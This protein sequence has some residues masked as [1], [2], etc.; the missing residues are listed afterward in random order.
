MTT[1]PRV[2][3]PV[4]AEAIADRVIRALGSLGVRPATLHLEETHAGLLVQAS[5]GD[6]TGSCIIPH[7]R[8]ATWTAIAEALMNQTA[9]YVAA[10]EDARGN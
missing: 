1:A 9:V 10:E 8:E 6:K 3:T 7:G 4:Q 5:V 2:L